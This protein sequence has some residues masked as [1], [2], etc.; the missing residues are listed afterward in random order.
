MQ[1]AWVT[2]VG[3]DIL[4]PSEKPIIAE[5]LAPG[6]P[7][8][9]ERERERHSKW[10]RAACKAVWKPCWGSRGWHDNRPL[11][12][13]ADRPRK[14]GHIFAFH[15]HLWPGANHHVTWWRVGSDGRHVH[16]HTFFIYISSPACVRNDTV[17]GQQPFKGKERRDIRPELLIL[18]HEVCVSLDTNVSEVRFTFRHNK[19]MNASTCTPYSV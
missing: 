5:R 15:H 17:T 6:G 1:F 11:T 8:E 14:Q 12:T 10:Q 13:D 9:R 19:E 7:G 18:T 2:A 4:I 3:R 16:G